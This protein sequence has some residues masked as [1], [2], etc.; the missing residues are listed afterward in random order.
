MLDKKPSLITA[1]TS[2]S[3]PEDIVFTIKRTFPTWGG[4]SK[5]MTLLM[6]D[7]L[8]DEEK[9]ANYQALLEGI[10]AG[11]YKWEDILQDRIRK[12]KRLMLGD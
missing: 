9:I 10:R 11:E 12:C 5:L 8:S 7:L 4:F 2:M 3:I 1:I 6:L